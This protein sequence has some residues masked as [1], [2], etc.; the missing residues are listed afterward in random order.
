MNRSHSSDKP[1]MSGA[2][3]DALIKCSA[4]NAIEREF[5]DGVKTVLLQTSLNQSFVSS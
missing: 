4:A 2:L 3:Q 5:I 1:W